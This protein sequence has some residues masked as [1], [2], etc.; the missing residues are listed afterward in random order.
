[1]L[2]RG[3]IAVHSGNNMNRIHCMGKIQNISILKQVVHIITTVLRISNFQTYCIKA[4]PAVYINLVERESKWL[5]CR[6]LMVLLRLSGGIL[7][8]S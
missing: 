6:D 3:I 5:Y 7:N 1:M 8:V 4:I 2:L